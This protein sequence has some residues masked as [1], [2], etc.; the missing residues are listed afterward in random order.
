MLH[1]VKAK[2]TAS[3]Q[4]DI[5]EEALLDLGANETLRKEI[6][7]LR[8]E[9]DL[10]YPQSVDSTLLR[11]RV[12]ADAYSAFT[13]VTN[14][15]EFLN[16][17]PFQQFK[18]IFSKYPEPPSDDRRGKKIYDNFVGKIQAQINL[19]RCIVCLRRSNNAKNYLKEVDTYFPASTFN[20]SSTGPPNKVVAIYV[21]VL[22]DELLEIVDLDQKLFQ[23]APSVRNILQKYALASWVERRIK[24]MFNEFIKKSIGATRLKRFISDK[25]IQHIVNDDVGN[26][27]LSTSLS[28]ANDHLSPI[29]ALRRRR[30]PVKE[31]HDNGYTHKTAVN[32]D[33]TS[34]GNGINM[35]RNRGSSRRVRNGEKRSDAHVSLDSPVVQIACKF[36]CGKGPFFAKSTLENH[37]KVC[38]RNPNAVG[39]GTLYNL[40]AARSIQQREAPAFEHHCKFKKCNFT[41]SAANVIDSHHRACQYNPHRVRSEF[42]P[43]KRK[44][45][46]PGTIGKQQSSGKKRKEN[47][48]LHSNSNLRTSSRK[49]TRPDYFHQDLRYLINTTKSTVKTLDQVYNEEE[50][51]EEE[52]K[53]EEEEEEQ[54]REETDEDSNFS[55]D[56][57]DDDNDNDEEESETRDLV[58][59]EEDSR[60]IAIINQKKNKRL[61]PVIKNTPPKK[62]F[63]RGRYTNP[64]QKGEEIEFSPN[65]LST[66]NI[67]SRSQPPNNVYNERNNND[68]SSS[69]TSTHEVALARI[70]TQGLQ[71]KRRKRIQWTTREVQILAAG[72]KKYKKGEWA[73][74]LADPASAYL[75]ERGRTGVNLKDKYRTE[76]SKGNFN[77]Q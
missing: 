26:V 5:I 34:P 10:N 28:R 77:F 30:I 47:K 51:E 11:R 68:S 67:T 33:Q 54:S 61:A 1:Q 16:N 31:D 72:L 73:K 32:N 20:G 50:E 42:S 44:K 12:L 25:D 17:E 38:A 37:Y 69:S 27:A 71:K 41:S 14:D 48:N 74:I 9:N 23:S 8:D 15:N 29:G 19:Q 76:R 45:R 18:S 6:A 43:K 59:T 66:N 56:D 58:I 57:D 4:V 2:A 64:S 22:R 13:K 21:Q 60:N 7:K 39:S 40:R 70:T 75:R 65:D 46:Q 49:R 36:K 63:K 35:A 55:D 3:I 24:V 52:E 53:E 62:N